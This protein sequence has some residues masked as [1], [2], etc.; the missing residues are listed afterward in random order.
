MK[1]QT[2]NLPADPKPSIGHYRSEL[3]TERGKPN[4]AEPCPVCVFRQHLFIKHKVIV[5]CFSSLE[6]FGGFAGSSAGNKG[7]I[8]RNLNSTAILP[9]QVISRDPQLCFNESCETFCLILPATQPIPAE[10]A[11]AGSGKPELQPAFHTCTYNI[12]LFPQNSDCR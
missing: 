2:L 1:H 11:L 7:G 6:T 9:N 3:Y 10:L 8:Y 12:G 5:S 4:Q